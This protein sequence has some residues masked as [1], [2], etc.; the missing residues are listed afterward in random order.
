MG[1]A[2]ATASSTTTRGLIRPD[3]NGGAG[4]SSSSFGPP[5][6]WAE[7]RNPDPDRFGDCPS[8]G[9]S[10]SEQKPKDDLG[11]DFEDE[12]GS[13]EDVLSHLPAQYIVPVGNLGC[14]NRGDAPDKGL[15]ITSAQPISLCYNPIPQSP[16]QT[17]EGSCQIV[18]MFGSGKGDEGCG[19]SSVKWD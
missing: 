4:P 5:G 9:N 3:A 7:R 11:Q 10:K 1:K 14:V 15:M 13:D 18:S 16:A 12:D 6:C 17:I 19:I 8:V 2:V